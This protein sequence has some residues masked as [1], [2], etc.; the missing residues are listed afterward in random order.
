VKRS[1]VR[2]R[3]HTKPKPAKGRVERAK[4]ERARPERNRG[5]GARA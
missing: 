4:L 2:K 5:V 3:N 1:I